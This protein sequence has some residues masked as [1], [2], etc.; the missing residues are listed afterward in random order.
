M[1]RRFY[2]GGGN[3]QNDPAVDTDEI[4]DDFFLTYQ[5]KAVFI[6]GFR[7]LIPIEEWTIT[8]NKI[9]VLNGRV[10]KS[11]EVVIVELGLK[12]TGATCSQ[13]ASGDDT[14]DEYYFPDILKCVTARVNS[15]FE[16]RD[17]DPFSVYYDKGLYN[18]VGSDKLKSGTG[19]LMVWLM[20]PY[21]ENSPRDTSY[22]RDVE[23]D[24]IIAA[25]TEAR[26]TQQEREDINF[27][28]RL[29]PVYKRLLSELEL[30]TKLDNHGVSSHSWQ[31]IPYWGGGEPNAPSQ[32]NLW[33][34]YADCIKI[35]GLK[36][37]KE[38]V[39]YCSIFSNF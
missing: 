10:F 22:A 24:I 13:D 1:V 37:K 33:K 20:M 34:N 17:D 11:K 38:H 35:T 9:K 7:Y 12:S 31:F 8:G 30:E 16:E 18:Q 5:V 6:E 4:I 36:L 23:C 21:D 15:Y 26:Y 19:F 39:K 2:I 32:A 25:A 14:Q 29:F 27:H 28:P 3:S